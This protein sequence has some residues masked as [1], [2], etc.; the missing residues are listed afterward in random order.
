MGGLL[1]L[2]VLA[3]NALAASPALHER[4][5][6][7]ANQPG[8]HCAVTV[9]AHGQVNSSTVEVVAAAPVVPLEFFPLPHVSVIVATTVALPPGRAPPVFSLPS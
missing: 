8:H 4:I 1:I 5:H 3:L 9:F 7:D 6:P 2:L